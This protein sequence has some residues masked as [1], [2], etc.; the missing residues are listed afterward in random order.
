MKRIAIAVIAA[1]FPICSAYADNGTYYQFFLDCDNYPSIYECVYVFDGGI[2]EGSTMMIRFE[3]D[4]ARREF[5][6][7]H[8]KLDTVTIWHEGQNYH[9]IC[10]KV[11]T[12]EGKV[13][14]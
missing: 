13:S 5:I 10:E 2:S 12:R 4:T 7:R 3:K 8:C 11:K 9:L 14:P 6:V 1:L